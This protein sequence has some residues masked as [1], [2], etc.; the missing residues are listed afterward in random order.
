MPGAAPPPSQ[1]PTSDATP[2]APL[3]A[4]RRCLLHHDFDHPK[5]RENS[6]PQV[7]FF[8]LTRLRDVEQSPHVLDTALSDLATH[9]AVRAAKHELGECHTL[10]ATNSYPLFLG[11]TLRVLT[12]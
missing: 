1:P 5:E 3:I 4:A 8:F 2:S 6:N 11:S 12:G 7:V 10:V 9:T